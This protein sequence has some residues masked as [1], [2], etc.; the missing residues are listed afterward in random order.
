MHKDN[1]GKCEKIGLF[2]K[3]TVRKGYYLIITSFNS[4]T[5]ET[6]ALAN[7]KYAVS[8]FIQIYYLGWNDKLII[9]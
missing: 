9:Q 4:T 2:F 7:T 5:T 3:Q 1:E 6:L 8:L